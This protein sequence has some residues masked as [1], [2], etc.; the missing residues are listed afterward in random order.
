LWFLAVLALVSGIALVAIG[1]W[2]RPLLEAEQEA[3]QGRVETALAGYA[4]SERRFERLPTLKQFAPAGHGASVGNQLALMYKLGRYDDLLEKASTSPP[5][6]ATHFWAGCALFQK[7]RVEEQP[8]ARIGWLSRSEQEFRSALEL[9]RTDWDTKYNYEL[10]KRL[11]QELRKQPKTPPKQL[12][13]L[14]RPQP[15][16]GGEPTKRVG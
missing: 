14:L 10:T 2:H 7:A 13:Q 11:L 12:L 4:E 8:E 5:M 6:H 3:D 1:Q 16:A 15:R 9:D